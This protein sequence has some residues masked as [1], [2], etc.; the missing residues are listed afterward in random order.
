MKKFLCSFYMWGWQSLRVCAALLLCLWG[1]CFYLVLD[2]SIRSDLPKFE[3]N[4]Y[5]CGKMAGVTYEFLSDYA[6][7]WPEYEGRSSWEVGFIH[8]KRG[9]DEKLKSLDLL[10]AWPSLKPGVGY[11]SQ[12]LRFEGLV[13]G[14][15]PLRKNK[16]DLNSLKAHYLN[17]TPAATLKNVS[18][19]SSLKLFYVEGVDHILKKEK[20]AYFW[21]GETDR[22]GYVGYCIWSAREGRYYTCRISYLLHENVL[23]EIKFT[24]EKLVLWREIV[25][26]VNDF[27]EQNKKVG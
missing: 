2:N 13:V 3:D 6:V 1:V 24:P 10:L 12:G 19:S 25:T 26:A 11:F 15:D 14:M 7:F 17:S 22:I 9:C 8:N 16:T 23:I 5:I 4:K 27:I 20:K 18:F 21:S